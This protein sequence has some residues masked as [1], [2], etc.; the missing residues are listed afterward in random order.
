MHGISQRKT[1][2]A[3][4][5]RQLWLLFNAPAS[6]DPSFYDGTGNSS[7][8]RAIQLQFNGALQSVWPYFGLNFIYFPVGN[9]A[10]LKVL[11]DLHRGWADWAVHVAVAPKNIARVS[12]LGRL[13]QGH[14]CFR[15]AL[16][17]GHLL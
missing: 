12:S 17:F 10:I 7:S 1:Q 6:R 13:I 5:D 15:A 9:H 8:M 11:F 3:E 2:K 14:Y 4:A 16:T